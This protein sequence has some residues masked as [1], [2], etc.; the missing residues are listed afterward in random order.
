[1]PDTIL[2]SE[3]SYHRLYRI[4]PPRGYVSL[5]DVILLVENGFLIRCTHYKTGVDI[6]HRILLNAI[7]RKSKKKRMAT[8]SHLVSILRGEWRDVSTETVVVHDLAMPTTKWREEAFSTDG[9]KNFIRRH[10]Y[11]S[12]YKQPKSSRDNL[13]K[14]HRKRKR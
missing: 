14:Q 1:M 10:M 11:K 2:L 4:T 12:K 5:S 13:L 7:V 3:Q 8:V 6:T 9:L